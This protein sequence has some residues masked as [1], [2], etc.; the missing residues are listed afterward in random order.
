MRSFLDEGI[1]CAIGSDA[2]TGAGFFNPLNSIAAAMDR[3]CFKNGTVLGEKQTITL[4]EALRC[5]TLYGAYAGFDEKIKGS[6]EVGKLADVVL[7]SDSL[8]GKSADQ[9]RNMHVEKT[10]MDG[11][12]VFEA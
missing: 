4:A 7:L 1:I 11:E 5:M 2:P 10:F 6:L 9:I 3:K 12:L 8:I